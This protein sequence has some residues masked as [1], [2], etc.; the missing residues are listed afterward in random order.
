MAKIQ[1][2]SEKITFEEKTKDEI[3][4]IFDGNFLSRTQVLSKYRELLP[5]K[6]KQ[7]ISLKN[8]NLSDIFLTCI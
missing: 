5:D 8:K 1:I 7:K 2:K 6:W 3:Q 4:R